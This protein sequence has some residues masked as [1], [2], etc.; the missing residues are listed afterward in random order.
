MANNSDLVLN[1]ISAILQEKLAP[2]TLIVT[3]TSAGH[4]GHGGYREGQLTH[5]RITIGGGEIAGLTR[6]T[7]HRK[8]YAQLSDALAAGLHAVEIKIVKPQVID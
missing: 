4:R 3:D 6:V 8:I 7:A 2:T 5:I 1:Q